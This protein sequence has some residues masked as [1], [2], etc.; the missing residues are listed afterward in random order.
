MLKCYEC[1]RE[2][3][4]W[5][6]YYHP[7]LGKK[8]FLCSRCFDVVEVSMKKYCN[9]ILKEF[10]KDVGKKRIGIKNIKFYDI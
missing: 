10:E 2:L 6:S 4:F 8:V 3:K 9:F 5:N 1:G 7:T